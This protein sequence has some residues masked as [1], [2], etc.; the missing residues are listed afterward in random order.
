MAGDVLGSEIVTPHVVAG[1]A[2]GL[3]AAQHADDVEQDDAAGKNR[4]GDVDL[5]QPFGAD[6]LAG[7]GGSQDQHTG[8]QGQE[9]DRPGTVHMRPPFRLHPHLTPYAAI[10]PD[11]SGTAG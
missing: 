3:M 2:I 6:H 1:E 8:R 4:A 11:A 5:Q 10:E 7:Q 9:E